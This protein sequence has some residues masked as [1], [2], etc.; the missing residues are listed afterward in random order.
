M[1]TRR[2]STV[3][4]AFIALAATGIRLAALFWIGPLRHTLNFDEG[5]YF[6]TAALWARGTV[7]HADF[8]A[9]HPPATTYFLAPLTFIGAPSTALVV[10]RVAMTIVGGLN[11][12]LVGTIARR[13]VPLWAAAIGALT[14]AVLPD[15]A[16]AERSIVLEPL[17]NLGCLIAVWV[18]LRPVNSE[19]A[20]DIARRAWLT[21]IAIGLA[22]SFKFWAIFLVVPLV[23]TT[24][25]GHRVR[26]LARVSAGAAATAALL[27]API[28]LRAPGEFFTQV[29]VFQ[30]NR[31]DGADQTLVDRLWRVIADPRHLGLGRL[32]LST[33]T[34]GLGLVAL[35]VVALDRRRSTARSTLPLPAFGREP[36]FAIIWLIVVITALF[37]APLHDNQYNSHLAPAVALV[38]AWVA[39][40]LGELAL[41]PADGSRRTNLVRLGGALGITAIALA[42]LQSLLVVRAE[43]LTESDEGLQIG[44][45]VKRLPECVF[46]FESGWL[47]MGDRWPDPD[48]IGPAAADSFVTGLITAN[49]SGRGGEL[50]DAPAAQKMYREAVESCS[51][52]IFGSRGRWHF[53]RQNPWFYRNFHLI[54]VT[55]PEG[56]DV[57]ERNESSRPRS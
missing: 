1:A 10:A 4:L 21:G 46:S 41:A 15:L 42:G 47:I 32:D 8:M 54:A 2:Q 38:A 49:E 14:Y 20:R 40:W 39:G 34:L 50:W 5:A 11:T 26:E 18:W 31:L 17:L 45:I 43:S 36:R 22:L 29:V 53:D 56:P 24:T 25:P 13:F 44:R 27:F 19:D 6:T 3:I 28:A 51:T 9:V 33:L 12:F 16:L 55:S 57:W 52:V 48:L 35:L 37:A 30:A 7:V 23:A